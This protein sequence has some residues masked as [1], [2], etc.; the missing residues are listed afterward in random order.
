MKR[1]P[2]VFHIL[3]ILFL[4]ILIFLYFIY[5]RDG[6][7]NK[8]TNTNKTIVLLGDSMIANNSYVKSGHS[9]QDMIE[10]IFPKDQVLMLAK[11]NSTIHNVFY[12]VDKIPFELDNPNT[13]IFLSAGGN[14]LLNSPSL[15]STLLNEIFDKYTLLVNTIITRLP[16]AKLY[17][18]TLYSTQDEQLKPYLTIW[19]KKLKHLMSYQNKSNIIDTSIFINNENDLIYNIEPSETGG[20][21]IANAILQRVQ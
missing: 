13:Y 1:K 18:L 6:F 4:S 11:N 17:L 7:T 9:I 16:N 3:L 10:Q 2:Y 14:D 21:K 8:N 20:Q 15:N 19:N 12:Q 5:K